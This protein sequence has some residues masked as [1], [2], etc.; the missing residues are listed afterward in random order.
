MSLLSTF[1]FSTPLSSFS[2]LIAVPSKSDSPS[3]CPPVH[4]H[5]LYIL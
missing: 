5:D 1:T 4:A 3:A 2:S